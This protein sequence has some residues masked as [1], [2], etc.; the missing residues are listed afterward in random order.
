MLLDQCWHLANDKFT[1][2]NGNN[3][4]QLLI[5]IMVFVAVGQIIAKLNLRILRHFGVHAGACYQLHL[6]RFLNSTV[7]LLQNTNFEKVLSLIWWP[8][9][10]EWSWFQYIWYCALFCSCGWRTHTHTH[11]QQRPQSSANH[12]S[13]Y[14]NVVIIPW[15]HEQWRTLKCISKN[16]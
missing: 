4:C 14:P 8:R 11:K 16:R 15:L 1:M 2:T 3:I 13:H 6:Q 7:I 10:S 12:E 9:Y 5:W